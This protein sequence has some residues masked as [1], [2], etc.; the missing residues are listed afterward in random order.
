MVG[1]PHAKTHW[2]FTGMLKD[3][4]NH[5]LFYSKGADAKQPRDGDN[6]V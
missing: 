6:G 4:L 2:I 5:L 3:R 1:S